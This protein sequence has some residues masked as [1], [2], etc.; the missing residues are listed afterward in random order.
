MKNITRLSLALII[1]SLFSVSYIVKSEA[2]EDGA[3][4]MTKDKC[5]LMEGEAKRECMAHSEM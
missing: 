1:F 5:M 4:G 3:Q 2:R